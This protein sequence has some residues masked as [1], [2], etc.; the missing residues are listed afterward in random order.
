MKV[1]VTAEQNSPDAPI[2]PRFGRA[3]YFAIAEV[4][5]SAWDHLKWVTNDDVRQQGHGAGITVASNVVE[6][7]AEAVVTGHAG[8]KAWQVLKKAGVQVFLGEGMTVQQ[9]LDAY[10]AGNL[11][12]QQE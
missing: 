2:D 6:W 1:I 5:D 11:R 4:T 10:C 7:G 3:H 9:A 12:E 8:P